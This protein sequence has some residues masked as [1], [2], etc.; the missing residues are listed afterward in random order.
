MRED[1][2]EPQGPWMRRRIAEVGLTQAEFAERLGVSQGTVSNWVA[3][4]R[5]VRRP[6][7]E[8]IPRIAAVLQVPEAEVMIRFGYRR[9]RDTDL[10]PRRAELLEVARTL[11]FE[12]IEIAIWFLRQR[13]E[14]ALDRA[15]GADD[16]RRQL[17]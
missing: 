12:E 15:L 2:D 7:P 3:V 10:H 11:P 17:S 14:E 9:R 4:G 1:Y 5:R 16:E 13:A 6:V 8:M